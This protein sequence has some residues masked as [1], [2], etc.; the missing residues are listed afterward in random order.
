MVVEEVVVAHVCVR[1]LLVD[2]KQHGGRTGN[3]PGEWVRF[4]AVGES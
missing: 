1:G 4:C 3:H 2:F